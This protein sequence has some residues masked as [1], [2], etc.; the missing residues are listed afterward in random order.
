MSIKYYAASTNGFYDSVIHKVRPQDAVEISQALYEYLLNQQS[1]GKL[2]TSD[3]NGYPIAVDRVT[4]PEYDHQVL[5]AEAKR[6]LEKSDIVLLR[7]E[8]KVIENFSEWREYRQHLRDIVSG[9]S[10]D[11]VLPVQP[12]YPDEQ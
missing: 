6:L 7:Q 5:I 4:T 12:K 1:E 8:E 2:I 3:D 11:K 9:R 10:T